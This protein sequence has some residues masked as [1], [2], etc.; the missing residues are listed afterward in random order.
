M[1]KESLNSKYLII[2]IHQFLPQKLNS[3][4]HD[5][6]LISGH[7]LTP[8]LIA[9]VA[10]FMVLVTP[11]EILKLLSHHVHLFQFTGTGFNAFITIQVITLGHS[12]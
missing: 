11:S 9:I 12:V 4:L 3:D 2:S 10:M 6:L 5:I 8:T 7:R 1:V